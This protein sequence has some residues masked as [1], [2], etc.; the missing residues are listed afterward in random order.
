MSLGIDGYYALLY[1][2]R[3]MLYLNSAINPILY[4]LMSSK[5]REGFL[6]LLGCKSMVRSKL[7]SGVR[8]GTF[9]TTSTN[10][11]LTGR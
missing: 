9:H 7:M 11:S 10:L 6:R 5:F 3:V 4:N 1:F 8:K 2:C